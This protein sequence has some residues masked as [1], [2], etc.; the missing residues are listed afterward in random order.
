MC[1]I[2]D[3]NTFSKVF[4]S[5]NKHHSEFKPVLHWV[6][7][8]KGKVV[9]GG[10]KYKGELRKAKKYLRLFTLLQSANKLVE[11]SDE[12]IDREQTRIEQLVTD[13]DF[14]DPHLIAIVIVSGCKL[15]CSEDSRA[16]K[17]IKNKALYPKHFD[18]PRI[19]RQSSHS[20]LLCD[21]N[22]ADCCTPTHKTKAL[23]DL[24]DLS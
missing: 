3:T 1:I 2:I 23:L 8:G 21:Q 10:S 13:P 7:V 14:D 11:I 15:I 17:Y 12:E 24:L 20:D 19:Y 4:E 9:Y 6:C 22:I 5:F 18:R 16:D